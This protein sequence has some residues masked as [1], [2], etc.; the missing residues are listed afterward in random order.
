VRKH[1]QALHRVEAAI[2]HYVQ[3]EFLELF[4]Q[5]NCWQAPPLKFEGVRLGT[6]CV[7]LAIGCPGT[8]QPDLHIGLEVESGWLVAGISQPGWIDRLLPHQ[9]RVLVTALLGLY[10]SAGVDLVREQIED[11]FPPPPPQYDVTAHG[12]V[13]WPDQEC[14]VEAIYD[15]EAGAWIA[16]QFV[17]GLARRLLPTVERRR[18]IFDETPIAWD[19]WVL[20][21]NQDV[22]GQGHPVESAAP[23]RVLPS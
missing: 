7:R 15:L 4:A 20:I 11:Q 10:K 21:W 12:L 18:L 6:N 19:R 1:L 16:P 22:A 13:V 14:D 8:S 17:R 23:V 5:S 9:R 2:S 3:R